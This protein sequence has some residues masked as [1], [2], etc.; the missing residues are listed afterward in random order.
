VLISRPLIFRPLIFR[1][2]AA[3]PGVVDQPARESRLAHPF[4]E[5][6]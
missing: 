2:A 1:T 3:V 6:H 5:T 4:D